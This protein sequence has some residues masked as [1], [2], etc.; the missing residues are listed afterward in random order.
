MK[1]VS[2][3]IIAVFIFAT[4]SCS[5]SGNGNGE[6]PGNTSHN[7]VLVPGAWQAPYAWQ[8]VKTQLEQQ[9]QKVI[10]VQLPGHGSDNTAPQTLTL[11]LYRDKVITAMDSF[12]GK[13]I[14][15]GHSL[16]GM[17]ISEVAEKVPGKIDKLVY[18]G[19][20]LPKNNQSLLDLA[21]TDAISLLGPSL[22]P[23]DD[24]LTL[25]VIHE[26]IT[27]IFIQDGSDKI[28]QLVLD[29]YR[30]EP[31]IP[32]LDSAKLTAG[33][34]G[35]VNKYYVHTL[36]DHV[37]SPDLQNRMVSAAGIKNIY[38]ITS[39]HCPFLSKP[40]SMTHILMQISK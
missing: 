20:Y 11:D 18:V 15:V 14:L 1:K 38:Q 3:L 24:M 6:S 19:A 7:F 27:N 12:P 22:V 33:N 9:G 35:S 2:K 31:A 34:F 26:N 13:V 21:N 25:G 5:K 4:A 37:I 40:D 10:I 39:S 32:F 8:Q 23:S 29:N 30:V 36:L 17:V 16:A 28:K